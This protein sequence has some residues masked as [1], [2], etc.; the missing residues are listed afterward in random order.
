MCW[1]LGLAFAF[2]LSA[3]CES[4]AR[5]AANQQNPCASVD[6]HEPEDAPTGGCV[7]QY[8]DSFVDRSQTI[9]TTFEERKSMWERIPP[10]YCAYCRFYETPPVCNADLVT[11]ANTD[12]LTW[13]ASSSQSSSHALELKAQAV[14]AELKYGYTLTQ[15]QQSAIFGTN[16]I[17]ST[18]TLNRTPVP[19]Y[20]RFVRRIWFD[21]STT[22]TDKSVTQYTWIATQPGDG[23]FCGPTTSTFCTFVHGTATA[24]WRT[25]FA[26][27]YAP[28]RGGN[29][30][31]VAITSPD[32]WGGV[33]EA[34]CCNPNCDPPTPGVNPCCGRETR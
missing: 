17:T 20:A 24:S 22:I 14:Y 2:T 31:G 6:D 27:E 34:H 21:S 30:G 16:T 5:Q 9:H 28:G 29:C 13:S 32:P 10:C 23:D 8:A 25:F 4:F 15:Q 1:A 26:H 33:R 18:P 11:L 7:W 3:T 12:T 19:C